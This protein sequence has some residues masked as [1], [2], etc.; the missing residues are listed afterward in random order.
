M[1]FSIRNRDVAGESVHIQTVTL[2]KLHDQRGVQKPHAEE[3][4]SVRG[5]QQRPVLLARPQIHGDPRHR[6]QQGA[7]GTEPQSV[8]LKCGVG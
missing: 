5:A 3:L 8:A 2:T 4:Q 7:V 6:E 1:P